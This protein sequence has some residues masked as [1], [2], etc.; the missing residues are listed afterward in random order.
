MGR[1]SEVL[2]AAEAEPA[3]AGELGL[4]V[5]PKW[6]EPSAFGGQDGGDK[7]KHVRPGYANNSWAR[8]G[9]SVTRTPLGQRMGQA[10]HWRQ[11]T[12]ASPGG[13]ARKCSRPSG[14]CPWLSA[15]MR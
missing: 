6:L 5:L 7:L 4:V 14:N 11:R 1:S 10:E 13:R 3:A 8:M 9:R 15:Y 12:W 2:D